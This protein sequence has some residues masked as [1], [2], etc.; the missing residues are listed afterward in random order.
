MSPES[1]SLIHLFYYLIFLSHLGLPTRGPP[2]APARRVDLFQTIW[3]PKIARQRKP[4][5]PLALS[6]GKR[7][8]KEPFMPVRTTLRPSWPAQQWVF[9]PSEKIWHLFR[10]CAIAPVIR[11]V[12]LKI[13]S[14]SIRQ[15]SAA[16]ASAMQVGLAGSAPFRDR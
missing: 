5:V 9:H 10:S 3:Q 12:R 13:L 2:R 4:T 14:I 11:K 16:T 6:S 8:P 7:H 1:G 15:R